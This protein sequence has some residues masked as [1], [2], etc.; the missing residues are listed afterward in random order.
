[1]SV[2]LPVAAAAIRCLV[3][4]L[5]SAACVHGEE[6]HSYKL[7]D[8]ETLNGWTV[9]NDCEVAVEGGL[10]VLKSG[11]GWLRSDHTYSDFVLRLEWRALQAEK[12][13]AG[14]YLRAADDGK[15]FPRPAYQVNLLQGQE[16][17][18]PRLAGAVTSGLV[19]PAGEW[20]TFEITAVGPKLSLKINGRPAYSVA[21]LTIPSGYVGLQVEV[22]KGG[23]FQFRDIRMTELT[24]RSLLDG[25]SL[26]HWEGA[27]QPAEVCWEV[28]EGE[29]VCTQTKGPWLR[30]MEEYGDFNLRLEY[31]V[32]PGGNSGV[33][34]RVPRDG[35][36]HR[37]DESQPPA[38]FEVQILD[39]SAAKH[40]RLKDY[41]YSGGVY[42]IAG[43]VRRVSKQ[44][45]E[46]NSLEINCD[47]HHITT[48]HN[49]VVIVDVTPEQHPSITL[50]QLRGYLGLQNHGG[51]VRFRNIRI[52][53]PMDL[54]P[55]DTAQ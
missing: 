51:A 35:K 53:G 25:K 55:A 5:I 11:N 18:V 24:H 34:V 29:L 31:C 43:P 30:S 40:S 50:R 6:G 52:G 54:P 16:G 15:P 21:G 28:Q 1:M 13:D 33:F 12:Y 38:G 48:A 27:G 46:W 22:P 4:L 19:K 44:P 3:V 23:Q 47:G 14:I 7:F 39:D 32:E 49:G 8:G 2:R 42:D 9:E 20:N 45:G 10:L 41:Q 17:H 37:D 36:H 26:A